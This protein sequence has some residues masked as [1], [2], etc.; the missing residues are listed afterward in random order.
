VVLAVAHK[1]YQKFT[2]EY[3]L[4]IGRENALFADLK[5]IYR[6]KISKLKYWSL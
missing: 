2:E 6:N 1:A 3:L 4:S 5:G